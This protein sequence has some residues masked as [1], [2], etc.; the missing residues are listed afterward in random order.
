MN[1][2]HVRTTIDQRRLLVAA[3]PAIELEP[4]QSAEEFIVIL[5][6]DLRNYIASVHGYFALLHQRTH[7]EREE[8]DRQLAGCAKQTLEQ[9]DRLIANVLDTVR[10]QRG[11]FDLM[12]QPVDLVL[13][14]RQCADLLQTDSNPIKLDLPPTASVHGDKER[15][16][17][18]LHN[19]LTNAIRHSPSGVPV[20][21]SLAVE[22]RA[23]GLWMVLAVCDRGAGIS[24]DILPRIFEPFAAGPQSTGLGLGLYLVR[25]IALAHGGT[26]IVRSVA[27]EGTCFE[28][29]LPGELTITR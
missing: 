3:Q 12:L 9:M 1:E 13:L 26:L 18:A 27:G 8:L 19:L 16:R 15:L 14:A 11:L 21:L 29:A 6:H 25:G 7:H 24:P 20:K 23:D 10:L 28:L 2:Q 22:T 5:A 4:N 17:Q